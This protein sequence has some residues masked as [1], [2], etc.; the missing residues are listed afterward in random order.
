MEKPLLWESLGGGCLHKWEEVGKHLAGTCSGRDTMT[1]QGFFPRHYLCISRVGRVLSAPLAVGVQNLIHQPHCRW[2]RPPG[3]QRA[4]DQ[5]QHP[6]GERGGERGGW[7][8]A[9]KC[10]WLGMP[11]PAAI[12]LC[13]SSTQLKKAKPTLPFPKTGGGRW[14]LKLRWTFRQLLLCL[15][16]NKEVL[17]GPS[18]K[19]GCCIRSLFAKAFVLSGSPGSGCNG[20]WL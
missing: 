12:P 2:C 3:P 6:H 17:R 9:C 18:I 1:K 16:Q 14:T 19:T 8:K 7:E 10:F 20:A 15:P 4:G 11:R 13:L 5:C